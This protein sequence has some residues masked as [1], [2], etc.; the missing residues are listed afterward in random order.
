M[1]KQ[2]FADVVN[3]ALK[4]VMS[5][6]TNPELLATLTTNLKTAMSQYAPS[7]DIAAQFTIGAF[8]KTLEDMI[9]VKGIPV[10]SIITVGG[11]NSSELIGIGMDGIFDKL[12][13]NIRSLYKRLVDDVKVDAV[14]ERVNEIDA[15]IKKFID[16]AN[17]DA[18]TKKKSVA[19]IRSV[20][21]SIN[22]WHKGFYTN[23]AFRFIDDV[24]IIANIENGA[25]SARWSY[26]PP[27]TEEC[28]H[29][30]LN[31]QHFLIRD[32]WA[33]EQGLINT[34]NAK[35]FDEAPKQKGG[36]RCCFIFKFRIDQMPD[37]MLT[38]KGKESLLER[39][40][41][42][43]S[44]IQQMEKSSPENAALVKDFREG[45]LIKFRT[46]KEDVNPNE[47]KSPSF[48]TKFIRFWSSK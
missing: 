41:R 8:S 21:K 38:K 40:N 29:E 42:I 2:E 4:V 20:L 34:T 3:S 7:S 48:F 37:S 22:K 14:S 16:W 47:N 15:R 43:E 23:R 26:S 1:D 31:D 27:Y 44:V 10:R 35:F 12:E 36:C 39:K 9:K 5:Q 33:I 24:D 11:E 30:P 25:I 6:D 32:C 19:D 46:N 17:S 45:N 13:S 28:G 18:A